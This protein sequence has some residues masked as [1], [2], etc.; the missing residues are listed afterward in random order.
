MKNR[1]LEITGIL[2]LSFLITSTMAVSG[3]VPEVL[4]YFS[5]YSRASIEFLMSAPTVSIMVIIAITPLLSR[6][7]NERVMISSGL[8]LIGIAGTAPVFLTSYPIILFSRICLGIGIGMVNTYAVTLVGER[9][10]GDLRQKLQGIRCSMETLGEASL[11]FIAGQLL[12][13]GWNIS[14]LVY[15]TAF[16]VLFLYLSFVPKIKT[17]PKDSSEELSKHRIS[18]REWLIILRSAI[19]GFL[20]VSL[21]TANAL[22]ISSFVVE[23]DLGTAIDGSNALSCSIL[24]GFLGGLAF[25]KLLEKLSGLLLSLASFCITAGLL[26][27]AWGNT[28]VLV[29]LGASLAGFCCTVALSYMFNALSDHLQPAVLTTANAAVLVGCNVG[30]ATTPFQLQCIGLIDDSLHFGFLTYAAVFLLLAVSTFCSF[31]KTSSPPFS[32]EK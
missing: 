23:S 5:G 7:I 3:G 27:I 19:L 1:T 8:L 13:F 18:H 32:V 31:K 28:M 12:V 21:L 10:E 4:D 16:V 22:R 30:A 15:L 26:I 6:Y 25:G 24:A 29:T 20:L 9:F 17:A 11:I 2:A 14:Y